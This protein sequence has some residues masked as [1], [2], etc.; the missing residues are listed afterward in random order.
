MVRHQ[1]DFKAAAIDLLA[2][3]WRQPAA[4]AEDGLG[5]PHAAAEAYHDWDPEPISWRLLVANVLGTVGPF[6]A[7]G[8]GVFYAWHRGLDG[9]VI[10][11]TVIMYILTALGITVG[12]HRLFAHRSFQTGPAVTLLAGI[13]G[14]MALQGPLIQWVGMHRLHHRYSDRR[15]DPHSPHVLGTAALGGLWGFLHAHI[16]WLFEYEV[17]DYRKYVKDLEANPW[18]VFVDRLFLLWVVLGLVI[19][20][21]VAGFMTGTR[22]GFWMGFWWG[23]FIRMLL[24]HQVTYSINSVCH[25]WGQRSF[26]IRDDSRDNWLFGLLGLGE[27]WH[28]GH[29]AFPTSA[30][31]GLLAGQLD[32]SY[33]VIR[34]L[35]RLGLAKDVRLPTEKDIRAKRRHRTA[36]DS[37]VQSAT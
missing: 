10:A 19:P 16:L 9:P 8:V 2:P 23:G 27:G 21:T 17:P 36:E 22:Y 35:E 14:S 11:V 32:F 25:L 31:H 24:L 1:D 37:D 20:A 6:L 12:F 29:H 13:L 33:C 28:N 3:E 15:G 5:E 26:A 4:E 18:V 34:C 7:F 30:K